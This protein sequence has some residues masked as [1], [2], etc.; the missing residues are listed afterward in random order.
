MVIFVS[1][2]RRVADGGSALDPIIVS[3]LL[4]RQRDDDPLTELTP[5]ERDVLVLRR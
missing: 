5:R 4:S 2:V 3:T 1:S